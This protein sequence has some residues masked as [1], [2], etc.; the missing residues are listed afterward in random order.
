ML[1][2]L[3]VGVDADDRRRALAREHVGAVALAAGHVDDAQAADARGDP[4][5]DDE[6]AAEPVVLL[7]HVGQRA[8]AG[9]LERRDARRAGRAGRSV[10]GHGRRESRRD[11]GVDWPRRMAAPRTADGDPRRQRRATTTSP[12][13][14]YDAK[15]GIDF[16]ADRPAAGAGQ[17]A[18]GAR[19][20]RP[21]E[22]LRPLAGDR[23]R[24]GLLLAEPAAGRRR[25]REATCT[26]ISPGM[27]DDAARQR[28]RG[29]GSTS[30]RVARRRRGAAVRGREL[31][32]RARPRGAAPPARPR[33]RRS[34]EFHRVLR[35]GGTVVFAG[36]PSRYGDRLAA[37]P[38]RGAARASRRCGGA[39][40]GARPRRTATATATAG[41]RRRPRARALR[42][43]PRLRARRARRA[44]RAA[45]ASTDV[46]RPRRGAA[47]ELVR[48]DATARSR[49]PPSPTTCRGCG[50]STPTAATSRC[51]RSTARLLE[52]RLPAAI[53]Y[54][55]LV[56]A[57]RL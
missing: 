18:Q 43:R 20:G 30:R 38:K 40:M 3:G 11:A 48:L 26:D 54:N 13:T 50:G 27:L 57:R 1:V 36:E 7:G 47:R 39:L 35:P 28:A 34:R 6:V 29:W 46:A 5:V 55:L 10:G 24:H 17:A 56:S 33:P 31:R 22:P 37:V 53:F 51:S 8:L 23:R 16:G 15:W 19:R 44:A 32:P 42:R 9:Q 41:A 21:R 49:R 12:P 2:G 14:D 25:S 45:P 52:G 4:L